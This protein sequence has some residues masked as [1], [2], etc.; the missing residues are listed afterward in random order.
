MRQACQ[1]RR[2]MRHMAGLLALA[3]AGCSSAPQKVEQ[4]AAQDSVTVV[5]PAVTDGHEKV[6]DPEGRL[7]MEGMKRNGLR[8]GV[9]T[10]YFGDGRVRSRSEYADGVLNGL[11]TVFRPGGTPYY[12]GQY[13]MGVESGEWRFYDEA[14]NLERTVQYGAD[15]NVLDSLAARPGHAVH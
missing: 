9:W 7:Q 3:W 15:G 5:Q 1:I 2:T 13:N 11:T 12:T 10:S 6:L 4:A 8:Q 14:G